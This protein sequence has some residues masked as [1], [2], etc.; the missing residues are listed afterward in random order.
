VIAIAAL[1]AS[2]LVANPAGADRHPDEVATAE[3]CLSLAFV[4]GGQGASD[5]EIEAAL[6]RQVNWSAYAFEDGVSEDDRAR[7]LMQIAIL[8][9]RRRESM[10][11]DLGEAGTRDQLA[12]E[13]AFCAEMTQVLQQGGR[14]RF[15]E[16]EELN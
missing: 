14:I 16:Q 7:R 4:D 1:F 2:L 5:A 6:L 12:S 9:M 10:L 13:R 11:E 8:E 15:G 3:R